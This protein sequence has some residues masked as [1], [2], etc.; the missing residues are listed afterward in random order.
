MVAWWRA[1]LQ[2]LAELGVAD[3]MGSGLILLGPVV[4][5]GVG[6][7]TEC[8]STACVGAGGVRA[9]ARLNLI[10]SIRRS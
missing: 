9:T 10:R 4:L 8:V 3:D 5:A 2:L 6:S 1:Q 7:L